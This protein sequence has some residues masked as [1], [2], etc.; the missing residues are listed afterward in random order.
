MKTVRHIDQRDASGE[1]LVEGYLPSHGHLLERDQD[2]GK[3][4]LQGVGGEAAISSDV[5][6]ELSSR[7][8]P[9]LTP[10]LFTRFR[11]H[12]LRPGSSRMRL[13]GRY[14]RGTKASRRKGCPHRRFPPR[15]EGSRTS[16]WT[17]RKLRA[18]GR[19][20]TKRRTV[21]PPSA[22][23]RRRNRRR[24]LRSMRLR[25]MA[26]QHRRFPAYRCW[27]PKRRG[28]WCRPRRACCRCC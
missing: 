5:A 21:V 26:G 20:R 16:P 23:A 10:F 3:P 7:S 14:R 25:R 1:N 4:D 22:A 12:H 8:C 17:P 28:K 9:Y 24:R 18:R 6:C 2:N 11:R 19:A 13:A 15:R 27:C